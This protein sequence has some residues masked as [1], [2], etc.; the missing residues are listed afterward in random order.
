MTN[1]DPM[2]PLVEAI[3]RETGWRPHLTTALR[4][5]QRKTGN[6]LRSAKVGGKRMARQ[7]WVKEFVDAETAK[8][9]NRSASST[10]D[11]QASADAEIDR[12]TA[13]KKRG[14]KRKAVAWSPT[15]YPRSSDD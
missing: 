13:P 6:Q 5:C 1:T 15:T 2:L 7:S 9:T 10:S 8:S 11:D 3:E 4:W 12:L 14:R